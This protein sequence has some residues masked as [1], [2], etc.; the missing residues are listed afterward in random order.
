VSAIEVIEVN[1]APKAPLKESGTP[2]SRHGRAL[3][4]AGVLFAC[5]MLITQ[6]SRVQARNSDMLTASAEARHVAEQLADRTALLLKR[7]EQA[8]DLAVVSDRMPPATAMLIDGRQNSAVVVLD[9]KGLVIDSTVLGRGEDLSKSTIYALAQKT[10]AG[11]V[12]I[13][14]PMRLGSGGPAL[15]PVVRA[16]RTAD[17]ALA[18]VLIIAPNLSYFTETQHLPKHPDAFFGIVNQGGQLISGSTQ[19]AATPLVHLTAETWAYLRQPSSMASALP[20][21]AGPVGD[22]ERLTAVASVGRQGLSAMV[23]IPVKSATADARALFKVID[24][25]VFL[26]GLGVF[27]GVVMV[28]RQTESLRDAL[29]TRSE[30]ETTLREEKDFFDITLSSIDDGVITIDQHQRITYINR[31][32]ETFTGC[33]ATDAI[34]RPLNM[35]LHLVGQVDEDGTVRTF[36]AREGQAQGV[37]ELTSAEGKPV[38]VEYL[39]TPLAARPTHSV[40]VLHDVSEATMMASKMAHQAHH[41][42]LTGLFNRTAFDSKLDAVLET[43]DSD[44]RNHVVLFLDLDQFKVV[45]DS[46]GH[47]A[48]DE[49]LQQVAFLFAKVLRPR[50]V[51]ARTGGDEFSVLLKDCPA[52]VAMAVAEKLRSQLT[53]FRF[54]WGEKTFQ[55]GVSIG[56]VTVSARCGSR[57]ELMRKA[58]TAC[59]IAKD[60]GRNRAHLYLDA[61]EAV[62][63]RQGELSWATRLQDALAHG[64]FELQGQRILSLKGGEGHYFEMLIRLVDADGRLVPPMAFLPAAERYG[65]MPALDRAVVERAL[66]M[67]G[68]MQAASQQPVKFA[69]NLSGASLSDP[70]LLQFIESALARHQVAPALICFEVTE[71]MAIA[72]LPLAVSMMSGL[73]ALGC[74]LA[75]DDFGSGMSSFSYLKQMPVDVVKIDGSFVRNMLENPVDRAM[76]E[77]VNNIAHQMGLRTL[78]EYAENPELIEALT[79]MGVDMLQGYGVCKPQSIPQMLLSVRELEMPRAA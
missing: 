53:S 64:N 20:V 70:Q 32:A 66:S 7:I 31:R 18:S 8:G 44:N 60:S 22:H 15:V 37:G 35:V 2:Q 69:I 12:A 49:L 4:V 14:T 58:D 73:K 13:G 24:P 33:P 51:L 9:A 67:H 76:V 59:Y 5:I 74:H 26:I 61:D 23:G 45:N 71:T 63:A 54:V 77:A 55:V 6:W 28:Q 52:R 78:A 17:G 75:L 72:N 62:V 68:Q 34:G 29:A 3:V 21:L 50:D 30:A 10:P 47:A 79:S 36:D 40:L 56:A 1:Q 65:L 19:G 39:L 42:P 46:C 11:K 38:I 25:V 43:I 27:I 16:I 57:D 41:D 48:G